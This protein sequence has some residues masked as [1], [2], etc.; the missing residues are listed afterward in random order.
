MK[1]KY[2][3]LLFSAILLSPIHAVA[4]DEGLGD[5][6]LLDGWLAIGTGISKPFSR[7]LEVVDDCWQGY[8]APD[9]VTPYLLATGC[10]VYG[11]GEGIVVGACNVVVGALDVV[12]FGLFELSRQSG[13]IE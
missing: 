5:S 4:Q 7:P 11:L 8:D 9:P 2:F 3:F 13:V 10:A 12:T 1:R 6:R